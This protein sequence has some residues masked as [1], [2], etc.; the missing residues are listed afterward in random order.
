MKGF[1]R[2]RQV[3]YGGY[4]AQHVFPCKKSVDMHMNP[5]TRWD[6]EDDIVALQRLQ[7]LVID[8]E[9]LLMFTAQNLEQ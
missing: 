3:D 7:S 5:G 1:S 6:K 9:K 4:F 8:A 2:W